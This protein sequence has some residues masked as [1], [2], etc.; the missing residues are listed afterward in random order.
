M[1]EVLASQEGLCSVEAVLS[2]VLLDGLRKTTQLVDLVSGLL[3]DCSLLYIHSMQ[4]VLLDPHTSSI[5]LSIRTWEGRGGVTSSGMLHHVDWY[6]VFYIH[7][8]VHRNRF[9]FK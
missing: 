7:V 2:I 6:V 3:T 9:I 1:L 5:I 4:L 8:T